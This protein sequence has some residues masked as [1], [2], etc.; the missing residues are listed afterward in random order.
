MIDTAI[1]E[2]QTFIRS[3][4]HSSRARRKLFS[5]IYMSGSLAF[6]VAVI[7][8]LAS[9]LYSAA[10]SGYH[11]IFTRA[12]YMDNPRDPTSFAP[13]AYVG[14]V[15]T[16]IVGTIVVWSLTV[17]MSVPIG[18]IAGVAMSELRT[19]SGR[20]L[21]FL[22][23]LLVGIPSLLFAI[24]WALMVFTFNWPLSGLL[25]ALA[26]TS[27]CIPMIAVNTFRA[28][29]SVP[30]E[31][32]EAGLALGVKPGQVMRRV[33]LPYARPQVVTGIMLASSRAIGET[34]P[35]RFLIGSANNIT[36]WNPLHQVTV[37]TTQMLY[38][39]QSNYPS[40]IN[41]AWSVALVMILAALALNVGS[42]IYVARST[43]RR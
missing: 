27:L 5:A 20:L 29:E 19:A 30:V 14:G 6:L 11:D 28:L 13:H 26:L 1:N 36:N 12:F 18:V 16:A 31:I 21:T 10:Q 35:I 23:E 25:G 9:I 38:L 34:A 43:R 3:K 32:R 40:Q 7:F 37:M 24:P 41:Q 4:S 2:R 33:L 42:R 39:L 22:I 17:A 8:P 15:Q